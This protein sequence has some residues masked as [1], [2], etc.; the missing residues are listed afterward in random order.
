MVTAQEAMPAR[1]LSE[2]VTASNWL[3]RNTWGAPEAAGRISI[4]LK[5]S[6]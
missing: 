3:L 6:G 1:W 2:M 4:F 5:T